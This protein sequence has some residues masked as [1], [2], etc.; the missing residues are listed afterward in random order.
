MQSYL[1]N[2]RIKILFVRTPLQAKLF[3]CDEKY[4]EKELADLGKSWAQIIKDKVLPF[5]GKLEL[6]FARFFHKTMGRPIKYIS[7]LIVVHIFKDMYDWTDEELIESVRFDKRFEYAFDLPYEEIT[8]CQKT[9]HN[10]RVLLQDNNMAR[11][12]FD[13]ATAHIVKIFNIDTNQQ[14]LDSTHI[15]SNMARLTRLG[16]FVRVIENFLA[17]MKKIDPKA[18]DNLPVRFTDRYKK[19]R[20]YFADARSKKTKHRLGEAANDMYYLIDRFSEHEQIRSLKVTKQLERV[21]KEHCHIYNKE[22]DSTITVEVNE[23]EASPKAAEQI[24]KK[25]TSDS[26]QQQVIVKDPKEM[27]S[28]ALQNPS[29]EDVTYGHKGSGYEATFAETCSNENPFQVITDVQTDTSV[30]SDQVK[31]LEVV[32][33]LDAN[34]LKPDVLY[35]DGTFTSGKNIVECADK[36]IDLQGNLVGVDKYPKKLKLA[37]FK[38]DQDDSTVTA[39]PA[40]EKPVSQR[41]KNTRKKRSKSQQSFLVH[42]DLEKCKTCTLKKRCPVKQHKQKASMSFSWEQLA[43]SLRRREQETKAFKERNNIRAGIESTNAELKKSHGLAKLRVR[44]QPRVDQTVIFKALACNIKRMVK[45][46]LTLPKDQKQP[47]NAGNLAVN[48]ANC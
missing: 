17:K 7:L 28:G 1:Q 3:P 37:D 19:R 42:F 44:G 27:S 13:R 15:L 26:S 14:R 40:G 31:T 46:V 10:F 45:Y 9:L 41:Q 25:Q 43:S 39:C 33:R 38:F 12:I 48:L 18:Y 6:E 4:N 22:D 30:I 34:G 32:N 23:P 36:G 20:G 2:Y 16:L 5:F 47:Q 21:F 35:T 24:N 8:L 11:I 29:D